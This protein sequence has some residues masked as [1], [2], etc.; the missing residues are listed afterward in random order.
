MSFLVIRMVRLLRIGILSLLVILVVTAC[1]DL[2][3]GCA[4][5]DVG[6]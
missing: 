1:V 4:F 2:T 5:A 3:M 6:M